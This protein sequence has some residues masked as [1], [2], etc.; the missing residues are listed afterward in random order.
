MKTFH[1]LIRSTN[2]ALL[3]IAGLSI[4]ASMLLSSAANDRS[5]KHTILGYSL[6]M[7]RCTVTAAS[8]T[9]ILF[10]RCN[11]CLFASFDSRLPDQTGKHRG[12]GRG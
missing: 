2:A 6:F 12:V 7:P 11:N 10:L 3:T 5:L 8:A 9:E 4:T 1:P